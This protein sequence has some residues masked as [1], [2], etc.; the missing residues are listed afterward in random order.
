MTQDE[1]TDIWPFFDLRITTPWLTLAYP[2]DEM[3]PVFADLADEGIHPPNA[4]PF[5]SSWSLEPPAQRARSIVQ[6]QWRSRATLSPA[7]WQLPFAVIV[8]DDIVG[9]QDAFATDFC[10]T[11]VATTG[12]WLTQS[13]Q[14]EGI[15]TEAR[16][17]ILHLLFDGFGA[18][19]ARTDAFES[20]GASRGVTEKL[21]YR[22][23]GETIELDGAGDAARIIRYRMERGDFDA[24]RRTDVSIHGVEDCLPL[25]DLDPLSSPIN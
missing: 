22:R 25:L 21:G 8:D 14:G 16:H 12:S 15:G 7:K 3:I 24:L 2:T 13:R 4:M 5:S 18:Q 19:Q 6:F 20:N 23:D 1:L 9:I 11:G 17:A 10:E